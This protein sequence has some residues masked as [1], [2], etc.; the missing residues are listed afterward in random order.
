MPRPLL[1]QQVA[2]FAI[3][4][5][6]L[7]GSAAGEA[8]QLGFTTLAANGEQVSIYRDEFGVP[9]IFAET[10]AGLFEAYGYTVAE[11][12]LWQLELNRRARE[13]RLAEILGP[14]S[15]AAD[16]NARTLGYTGAELDTQLA[17]LTP[18]EQA[19]IAAYVDGIN[20]YLAEVVA[21]DPA[22]KLPFEFQYLQLG[23][24]AP[25]TVQDVVAF[26]VGRTV[27]PTASG[28]G[29][30]PNQSLLASLTNKYGP[31][32]GLAVFDD[33]R[34]R[35][36]PDAPVSVPR[37]GAIGKR[38]K[39]PPPQPAQLGGASESAPET[40]DDEAAAVLQ[41]LGVPT[42]LGSHAWVVS[43]A[44]S[45]TGSPMLF[46][47]P[48]LGFNTPE[49]FHEV[50]LKGGNG[51]DVAGVAF[52]GIPLVLVG[53]TDHTAWSVTT[54]AA[55]D[56]TDTYIETLCGG[57]TG[58]LFNGVC[59]PFESRVETIYVRGA[60]PVNVTVLRSVHGP[61][62]GSGTGVRFTRKR[63]FRNRELGEF[64]A[65]LT[66][67]RARNLQAFQDGVELIASGINFVYADRVGNIAYWQAGLVPVRAA[68]FDPRLPL[69]GDGSA[70]WTGE[71]RP[72]PASINPAR[73]W[74]ASWNNRPSVDYDNP[75]HATFGKQDRVREIEAHL[76]APGL[77][78]GEDMRDVAEDIART[79]QGG[80]GRPARELKPYLL[81][82]LDTVAPIHPLASQARVVL[83]SWDGSLY[84][85]ARTSTTVA[86][87]EVIFFEWR[88]RM[89]TNTFGDELGNVGAANFPA[90]VNTLLHVLDDALADGSGVPPS[91]D[92]FNG[93]DPNLVMSKTFDQALAALGSDPAA[94]ASRPRG[95]IT[96]ARSL[97]PTIPSAGSILESNRGTYAQIVLLD[98]PKISSENVLTLGQS[99]FIGTGPAGAPVFDPHF[100]DQL[101]LY[102]NFHYKPMHLFRNTELKE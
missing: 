57:G 12:R 99:G 66:L 93:V 29:E 54:A 26:F 48:Q 36:D 56:N 37:E 81:S 19:I 102:R 6:A 98:N 79:L 44:K 88:R 59:T 22:H 30:L 71:F 95:T 55:V 38:Q 18:E 20:R 35:N 94:W 41:S 91:R 47:G 80:V 67:D 92:Y 76:E 4:A 7:G 31:V 90:N 72:L 16:R 61:V 49:L 89:L 78:S 11:D 10:N 62:V 21:P 84:D 39:A 33:L 28:Q 86:P 75:D 34:W 58:Y 97:F 51:F 42:K 17:A 68:G 74:L 60:A 96:F 3:A 46:G 23:Q 85:D 52:A 101:E 65:F 8:R 14:D 5:V 70:E 45:T 43:A 64:H 24:P 82:A 13:G 83:E 25:W 69:P 15:L 77:I 2:L 53:R 9:H 73:G 32:D 50:Q 87:G 40:L 27:D 100:N 63:A 1:R